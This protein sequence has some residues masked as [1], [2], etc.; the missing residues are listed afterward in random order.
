V[1][2]NETWAALEAAAIQYAATRDIFDG[3]ALREA[4]TADARARYI[5]K[6][7]KGGTTEKRGPRSEVV[8]PYG[9]EK[10]VLLHVAST[11]N[12]KWVLSTTRENIDKPEKARYRADNIALAEAI[13]A[14]LA[15]R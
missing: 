9:K 11:G 3:K 8:L 10:G 6:T 7:G 15:T 13:E 14:E 5:E 4:A 2:S 12:L 1:N